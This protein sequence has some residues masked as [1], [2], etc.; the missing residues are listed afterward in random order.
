MRRGWKTRA[1]GLEELKQSFASRGRLPLLR[2]RLEQMERIK[3][4]GIW[5][6]N[7]MLTRR[8]LELEKEELEKKWEKQWQS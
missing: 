8:E 6:R 2:L 7:L 3:Q 4:K 1:Q 5:T